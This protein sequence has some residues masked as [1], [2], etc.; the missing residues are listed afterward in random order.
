MKNE[1]LK[2]DSAIKHVTGQSV[3]VNDLVFSGQLVGR[4]VYSKVASARIKSIDCAKALLVD[5]V[6]AILTYKDIPGKNQLG[7]VI[8]DEPCLAEDEV[9][10]IGQAIVLIAAENLEAA[11]KAEKLIQIEFEEL[12]SILTLQD[13]IAKNN[14]LAP[15]RCIECGNVE[16]ALKSAPHLISGELETGAQEHWYLETQSALAVPGEGKEMLVHASSQNPAETQAIV[17]EVL[18]VAKNEIEVEVRRMGGGFGGKETQGNHV[19][20]WAALLAYA[21]RRP[22]NIQLFRDDDQIITGKR[23][24]F[25]SNYSV[26][27]DNKGKILA[28]SVELNSDAGAATDLSRAILERAMLHAENSYFIPNVKIVGK[29]Y[30]TNLPSNTAFRGFGGPQGM[31]VI[32]TAIDRVARFLKKDAAEIRRLNFYGIHERNITPYG[33]TVRNSR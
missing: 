24:R 21:T 25:L 7:P 23:H 17:A 9:T 26:G 2:H 18:G 15:P 27:F 5:G 6:S 31:A 32:E 3:Y 19:A 20:A 1:N 30:K 14:L 33:E 28:Y 4:V 8:H 16:E 10:F 13:A 11:F 22:V 12:E 29:A